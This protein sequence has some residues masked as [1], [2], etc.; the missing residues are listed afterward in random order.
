MIFKQ[1]RMVEY[2]DLN[3]LTNSAGDK[4][5]INGKYGADITGETAW[6]WIEE[7]WAETYDLPCY[8]VTFFQKP[9][10]MLSAEMYPETCF[11]VMPY[12][13]EP[14]MKALCK[15]MSNRAHTMSEFEALKGC[16]LFVLGDSDAACNGDPCHELCCFI[17]YNWQGQDIQKAIK[18]FTDFAYTYDKLTPEMADL[19][20]MRFSKNDFSK[21]KT[22]DL[23]KM[24]QCAY[25]D[26]Y[27][28]ATRPRTNPSTK[29]LEPLE[30]ATATWEAICEELRSRKQPLNIQIQSASTRAAE[31]QSTDNFPMKESSHER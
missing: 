13:K 28:L 10:I 27:K 7:N 1:K 4:N 2:G 19:Y 26:Y 14:D 3:Y 17:P 5:E 23:V 21:I 16:N 11:E 20:G 18:C 31:S 25:A 29:D 22:E 6:N 9:G 12:T 8:G 30:N 15:W 24:E